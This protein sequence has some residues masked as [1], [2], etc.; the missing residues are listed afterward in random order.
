MQETSCKASNAGFSEYLLM[1]GRRLHY[2]HFWRD[3]SGKNSCHFRKI[4]PKIG[5]K[6][7][8]LGSEVSCV[9]HSSDFQSSFQRTN[10]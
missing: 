6:Y 10:Q 5:P 7:L 4:F 1:L 3:F 8:F 9:F 2:F